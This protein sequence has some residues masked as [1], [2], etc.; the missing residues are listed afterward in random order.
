MVKSRM[1]S[2]VDEEF[3]A[4][5]FD[6]VLATDEGEAGAELEQEARDMA[7]ERALDVVLVGFVAQAEEIEVVGVFERLDCELRV[8]RGQVA[9]EVGERRTL[10]QVQPALDAGFERRARPTLPRGLGR[11]PF[12]FARICNLGQQRDEVEPRQLGSSLLPNL[13]VGTQL[14]EKAHVFEISRGKSP[15]VRE[16]VAQVARQPLDDLGPP[17]FASLP[18]QNFR[19]D[20]VVQPHQ[21]LIERQ[22]GPRPRTLDL[23]LEARHPT[24]V[25]VGHGHLAHTAKPI[26]LRCTSTRAA[27]VATSS[28]RAGSGIA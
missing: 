7:D 11:V 16:G 13:E 28:L 18:P 8:G 2:Q 4:G 9:L 26:F 1:V 25:L 21:L 27:S 5:D 3:V 14:G 22:H 17:A 15:H 20:A 6:A 10:P 12:A 24:R 19:P 23:R